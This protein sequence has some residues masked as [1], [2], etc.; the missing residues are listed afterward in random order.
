MTIGDSS[1]IAVT[2]KTTSII[3]A[4]YITCDKVAGNNGP[5]VEADQSSDILVPSNIK[6]GKLQ[7]IDIDCTSYLGLSSS[8]IPV[9]CITRQSDKA[10][11]VVIGLINKEAT[12]GIAS[13]IKLLGIENRNPE[14]FRQGNVIRQ[15]KFVAA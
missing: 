14:T 10:D 12:E 9:S 15:Q 11:I 1:A 6:I 4:R 7:I 2:D 5:I 13:T 3:A 8:L